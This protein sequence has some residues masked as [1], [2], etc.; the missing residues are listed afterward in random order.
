MKCGGSSLRDMVELAVS[1][2]NGTYQQ[3]K[4]PVFIVVSLALVAMLFGVVFF[5]YVQYKHHKSALRNEYIIPY[6]DLIA[7]N[8]RSSPSLITITSEI[9]PVAN[10]D[11]DDA[12]EWTS[13]G[14]HALKVKKTATEP[15]MLTQ[16]CQHL[17]PPL[18]WA[19]KVT[20]IAFQ[21]KISNDHV[22]KFLGLTRHKEK[23]HAVFQYPTKGMY[24]LAT[25][26]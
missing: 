2:E 5:L 21:E 18:R 19:T 26:S 16:L 13:K 8:T 14:F 7:S 9:D 24:Y 23:W 4:T 22:T 25:L 17:R 11:E 10:R 6:E 12:P 15:V 1:I 3:W 20:L